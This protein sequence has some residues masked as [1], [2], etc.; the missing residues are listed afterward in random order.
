MDL[1]EL[2]R[3][4][5][6]L[7]RVDPLWAILTVPEKINNKWDVQEFFDTGATEIE[8]VL[9]HLHRFALP[10][11]KKRALDFGCGVGR[12]TQALCR[13]F[14]NCLGVD[15]APSMIQ[16]A[17]EYNR[18]G[19]RCEYVLNET[20]G[21]PMCETDRWDF[22]YSSI[23]LQHMK[24]EYSK[25]YI[26]EFLRILSPGGALVFQLPADT[27]AARLSRNG[28]SSLPADAFRASM[29][30]ELTVL[31]ASTGSPVPLTVAIRNVSP[32]PWPPAGLSGAHPIR[33][34]NH[35]L[36]ETGEVLVRD[37]ARAELECELKPQES[38]E[39]QLMINT[40]ANPGRYLLELDM[41]QEGVSWFGDRGSEVIRIPAMIS[42]PKRQSR[43]VQTLAPRD[44][45]VISLHTNDGTIEMYGVPKDEVLEAIMSGGGQVLDVL[46]DSLAGPE[47][48]S[49][50][51]IVTKSGS[52]R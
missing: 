8:E 24:P 6:Q 33:L 46:P 49:Y 2:Q 43:P 52:S 1:V 9:G 7:G 17:R 36:D 26:A 44:T 41:V 14:E 13:H 40:P 37:D 22:I 45:G 11:K 30:A 12:L 5:N 28:G 39:L 31:T 18:H 3:N 47:W 4:W 51:Y 10:K 20:D 21:L 38:T 27:V 23:V 32:T 29:K 35:W 34:G 25:K 42:E 15:I 50:F 48:T 19:A 16:R